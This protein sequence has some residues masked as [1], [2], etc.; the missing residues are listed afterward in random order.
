MAKSIGTA[1]T[2]CRTAWHS[3]AQPCSQCGTA[4][5]AGTGPPSAVECLHTAAL[6]SL[7][8]RPRVGPE[9][10]ALRS[11]AQRS[12]V[13]V[14]RPHVPHRASPTAPVRALQ[15]TTFTMF[16]FGISKLTADVA[17]MKTGGFSLNEFV[18]CASRCLC[19]C[20]GTGMRRSRRC[21][22]HVLAL[23]SGR[24]PTLL[25]ESPT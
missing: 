23:R 13:G 25:P 9:L 11:A 12:T 10:Q 7:P 20:F 24:G 1:D 6:C 22:A 21:C 4:Y 3:M 16:F 5:R 14:A 17:S 2:V 8:R 19:L 15:M 18:M